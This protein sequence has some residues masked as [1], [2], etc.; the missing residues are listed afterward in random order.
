MLFADAP[1]APQH[2]AAPAGAAAALPLLDAEKLD[3]YRLAVEFVALAAQLA[4]RRGFAALRDQLDR[5]STSIA[6]NVAEGAGRVSPLDKAR[7]YVIAR[8][9]AMEC[10]AILDVLLARG[11]VSSAAHGR[12]RTIVVRLVQMLTKLNASMLR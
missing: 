10:G 4:P 5:A 1:D 6:L 3:A 8:G 7:F 2:P 12:A 11:L 9:S